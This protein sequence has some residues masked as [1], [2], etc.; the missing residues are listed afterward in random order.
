MTYKYLYRLIHKRI[1][2]YDA[3]NEP[4]VERKDLGIFTKEQYAKE[5]ISNL[6]NKPGFLSYPN[7][8]SIK[9]TR[10]YT[11]N[12]ILSSVTPIYEIEHEYYY[13]ADDC[14]IVTRCGIFDNIS[15]AEL[16]I[17][18]LRNKTEFSEH[19]D[20]FSIGEFIIDE[21]VPTWAQGFEVSE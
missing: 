16:Y 4:I 10:V 13:A 8:F 12:K 17:E 3:Y 18:N 2:C 6:L 21:I 20:G 1:V 9:R 11:K 15:D 7:D 14:D 19:K 5:A